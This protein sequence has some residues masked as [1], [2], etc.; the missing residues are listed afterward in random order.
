[1]NNPPMAHRLR[2][3][4]LMLLVAHSTMAQWTSNTVLNTAVGVSPNNKENVAMVS[5]GAGG[6]IIVWEENASAPTSRDIIAQRIDASG[7]VTWHAS[8]VVVS[9][10]V[11]DQRFPTM[12]AD[13]LGGAIIVWYDGRD[14]ETHIY[15][16]RL[17][18]GG[19]IQWAVDGLPLCTAPGNQWD[20]VIVG[21]GSGGAIIVWYEARFDTAAD[22]F[23]QRIS[24]G[25]TVQWTANGVPLCTARNGQVA[26]VIIE[27][28]AGGA[29][30]SWMDFR[31][32]VVEVFSQRIS[33]AGL[34]LWQADGVRLCDVSDFQYWPTMTNDGSGGAIVTWQDF[35]AAMISDIYAQRISGVGVNQWSPSGVGI[36]T[37]ADYQYR[38]QII[39]DGALGAILS[40]YDYRNGV[41]A[42][43]YAQRV[44]SL[45]ASLWT[46]NGVLICGAPNDQHF[47]SIVKDGRGGAVIGWQ[48]RRGGANADIYAQQCN[49]SGVLGFPIDGIAVSTAV[50]VQQLPRLVSNFSGGTI[51]A[52]EDGRTGTRQ[53]IFAH[54]IVLANTDASFGLWMGGLSGNVDAT[55][56]YAGLHQNALDGT[57]SRDISEP[58]TLPSNYVSVTSLSLLPADHRIQ[59]IRQETAQLAYRA[60][61]W[62]LQSRTSATSSRVNLIFTEDRIPRQFTPILYD[63][64]AGTYQELRANPVYSYT[65]PPTPGVARDFLLLMGDSTK[66]STT[67]VA[68]NGGEVLVVGIP[69]TIRWSSADSSGLLR[70]FIYYTLD[71]MPPFTFLDSTDGQDT[72]YVWTPTDASLNGLVRVVTIDSVLNT[73]ADTSDAPFTIVAGDS[74]AYA[75]HAGWN[76]IGIPV[77]QTDMSPHGVFADD[78]GT[79]PITLFRFNAITGYG[80]PDTLRL[81]E[82]Y[83]LRT[84]TAQTVDAVGTAQALVTRPLSL[85][86]NMVGN[87]FP[88]PLQRS[89]LRFT[90]GST[91]K[92]ITEAQIAGWVTNA[93]YGF[94]GNGYV[95]ENQSLAV[96]NGYWMRTLVPNLSIVFD[97]TASRPSSSLIGL[98]ATSNRP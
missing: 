4:I 89:R 79:A 94:D 64:A 73:T 40:W 8:G 39:A 75:T 65:S 21:D 42:D 24:A 54:R 14:T 74:V 72:S 90:D 80:T 53:D 83:W 63:V 78:F 56:A 10:A 31:N 55:T 34:T 2:F 32:G 27:D 17:D 62:S 43:I 58:P 60:K 22:I 30:V 48:D 46:P 47:P 61:R 3:P 11:G 85:G 86:W 26:P 88:A 18:A 51:L 36:C 81:G 66:P 6:A 9:A 13:G 76:M 29:V 71:G 69:G 52:W 35:R 44:S 91:T 38:P 93:L 59:D 70:H 49:S 41:N 96:W 20:P 23:A 77:L 57:D 15:A 97:L 7:N 1:M 68:P 5:D 33:H 98:G 50:N 84:P 28:D 16:Q 67:I 92:T 37:A 25:G 82:G 95:Q 45:G 12:T 87:P 19:Q